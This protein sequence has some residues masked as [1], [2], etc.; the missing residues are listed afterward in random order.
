MEIEVLASPEAVA[1]RAAAIV[2]DLL[3]ARPGAV[4]GLPAGNTP[5]PVY[6]ELVRRHREDGLSFAGATAFS[7]DEYVGLP[8]D[9]PATF[10]RQLDDGL[11]RHVDLSA[12]RTHAPDG[13]AADLD[14]ESARYEQAIARAGGFDLVLLG[15]GGNGHIAFN[16]PGSPATSRTRVV[17]LAPET[18]AGARA[19]FADGRAPERAVTVGVATILDARRCLLL[20]CGAAKAEAVARALGAPPTPLVPASALQAHPRT[21][22]LLDQAAAALLPDA[23]D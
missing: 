1:A 9:H 8:P 20:A 11:F 17:A 15:I 3:R 14:G 22:A 19:G 10:R 23:L 2:A 12:A 7:L 4:L 5:R 18:R 16:E 6:A 13:G 21:T